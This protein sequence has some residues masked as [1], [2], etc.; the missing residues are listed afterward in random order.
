MRPRPV[1]R[2]LVALRLALLA[3]L[4]GCGLDSAVSA[5]PAAQLPG[6]YQL[7]SVDGAAL[8]ALMAQDDRGRLDV[9]GATRTLRDDGTYAERFEFRYVS[10]ESDTIA[11]VNDMRGEYTITRGAV[12]FVDADDGTRIQASVAPGGLQLD[13]YGQTFEYRK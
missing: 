11:G 13:V 9:V 10:A 4:A 3:P 7:R 6:T 12:I 2:T 5:D 1:R 8:P